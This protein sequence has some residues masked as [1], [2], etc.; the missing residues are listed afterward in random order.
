[1][2]IVSA[3]AFDKG[4]D[5]DVGIGPADFITK[6]VGLDEL[7][8][9]L[10]HHLALQW[11]VAPPAMPAVHPLLGAQAHTTPPARPLLQALLQVVSL[12]YPRGVHKVLDQIEAESPHCAAWLTPLRTL[13]QSFQFDHMTPVIQDAIAR[14]QAA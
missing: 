8:D 4:Q 5:N 11:Q 1:M 7:L 9:W 6:P 13:A 3:N 10:G 14:S 12:G 2:A